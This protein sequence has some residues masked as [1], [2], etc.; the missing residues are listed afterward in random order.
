MATASGINQLLLKL[1]NLTLDSISEK[2]P[3]THPDINP[4]DLYR[5]HVSEVLAPITGVAADKI[6][7]VIQWTNALDK[8]DFVLPIPALRI[9]GAKPDALGAEW[10]AKVRIFCSVSAAKRP[11]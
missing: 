11:N 10:A 8:G 1:D 9:K 7:P 2:Y 3:V 6:H 4:Y 5:V